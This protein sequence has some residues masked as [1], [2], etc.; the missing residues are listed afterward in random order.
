MYVCMYVC[1]YQ[2]IYLS[3]LVFFNFLRIKRSLKLTTNLTNILY[4]YSFLPNDE[5]YAIPCAIKM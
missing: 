1:M 5:A 4:I 3:M 2:S